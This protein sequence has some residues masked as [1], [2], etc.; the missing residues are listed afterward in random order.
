MPVKINNKYFPQDTTPFNK[1]Q[2]MQ[3]Q[4]LKNSIPYK[5]KL[6]NTANDDISKNVKKETNKKSTKKSSS[7]STFDFNTSNINNFGNKELMFSE[8]SDDINQLIMANGIYDRDRMNAYNK[9]SRFPIIDPYGALIN[10]KEYIFITKPDLPIFKSDGSLTS[11][12]A[13]IPFFADC[14]LRYKNVLKQLQSSADSTNNPF[15]TLLSNHV[16]STLDIPGITGECIETASNIMGTKI[17]YRG[18]SHRS[19][20][21]H[22]FNL[23]F[24]DNKFLDIY[25]LF[26]IYDEYEKQK[27][28]CKIDYSPDACGSDRWQNYI[29]DKVL[30]DQISMFKFIV[31][32]DGQR[33]LYW[34]KLTGCFPTSIPR[35]SWSDTTDTNPTKLT[36]G[37]KCHFVRDMDPITLI[38]F[39]SL[40]SKINGYSSAEEFPLFNINSM[41]MDGRWAFCPYI[42]ARNVKSSTRG[43]YKEYYLKWKI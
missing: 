9:F 24:E 4:V 21:D 40:V 17:Y 11:S 1:W 16:T 7:R 5:S 36:I 32:D 6:L 10:T 12:I 25:M 38:E 31:S 19:D 22:D 35:D 14:N 3:E 33:L 23:E 43:E 2:S 15:M 20:E 30:H 41:S 37:W 18:T 8:D 34:I 26:K 42:D 29:L 27:W 28:Y 39:N 13:N